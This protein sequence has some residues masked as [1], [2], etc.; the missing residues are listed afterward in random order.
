MRLLISIGFILI[1]TFCFGQVKK[2]E[3]ETRAKKSEVPEKAIA[4]IESISPDI[5]PKWF[6]EGIM[7]PTSYEAKFKFNKAKYS[8]EFDTLG[9]LEDVEILAVYEDLPLVVRNEVDESLLE[10]YE[11]SKITRVQRQWSGKENDIITAINNNFSFASTQL[12][13]RYEIELKLKQEGR[14]RL[15]EWT[16]DANG[17][18]ISQVIVV[19]PRTDHLEY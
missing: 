18:I 14:W 10:I 13:V 17:K 7:F 12:T 3:R 15:E 19:T 2:M 11:K 5:S 8:V 1:S 9:N 6:W 4:F 16:V